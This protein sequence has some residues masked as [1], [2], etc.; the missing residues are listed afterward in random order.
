MLL[1]VDLYAAKD[2]FFWRVVG[3]RRRNAG[4]VCS[5]AATRG[6]EE[7]MLVK[8]VAERYRAATMMRWIIVAASRS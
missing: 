3:Q 2:E 5:L 8:A 1:R 6:T 7:L 4:A